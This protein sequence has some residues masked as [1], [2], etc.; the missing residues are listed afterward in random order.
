MQFA[1]STDNEQK[2]YSTIPLKLIQEW[3]LKEVSPAQVHSYE[4]KAKFVDKVIKFTR[5]EYAG[6]SSPTY[7]FNLKEPANEFGKQSRIKTLTI[8]LKKA[9]PKYKLVDY[10]ILAL[11]DEDK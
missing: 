4:T 2:I 6:W 5:Q 8:S 7:Y 10:G 1:I 3:E 9:F 11:T